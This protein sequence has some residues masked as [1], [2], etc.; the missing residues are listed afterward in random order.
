MSVLQELMLLRSLTKRLV[1][2][3]RPGDVTE[4][5]VADWAVEQF[6]EP[7]QQ[8]ADCIDRLTEVDAPV[9]MPAHPTAG[10]A[11]RVVHY[12]PLYRRSRLVGTE[13]VFAY[14][15]Y[16]GGQAK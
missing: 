15:G 2:H 4:G 5:Y 10:N 13:A 7:T 1:N 6:R 11:W 12:P 3:P 14:Q 8:I 9:T 16:E